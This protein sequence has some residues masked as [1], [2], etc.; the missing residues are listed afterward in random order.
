VFSFD[1]VECPEAEKVISQ[2]ALSRYW[3]F[4]QTD[5]LKADWTM[6]I[7]HLFIDTSHTYEQTFS[8]L[9]KFEPFVR[10]GGIITMHDQ[11]TYPEVRRAIL[12]YV[13]E[14]SDLKKYEYLNNN[15]LTVIFKQAKS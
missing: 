15:G 12:D 1:I 6:P 10:E 2:Y 9:R 11:V 5:D 8:E 4:V 7:D 3:Q 13:K 14:R